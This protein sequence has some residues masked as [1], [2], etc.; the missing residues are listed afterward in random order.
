LSVSSGYQNF[1]TAQLTD[2]LKELNLRVDGFNADLSK[3]A[4]LKSR[5]PMIVALQ[6]EIT[7]KGN[8]LSSEETKLLKS[9]GDQ[10]RD[11]MTKAYS[12]LESKV[13][14]HNLTG[15]NIKVLSLY[16]LYKDFNQR[17]F[18]DPIHLTDAAN[19][20]LAKKLFTAIEPSFVLPS[21]AASE[22]TP[23]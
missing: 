23:R 11:R 16:Q 22:P 15:T 18:Y 19:E 10:Y 3:V 7:G 17:A 8:A 6:P 5:I 9:L 4:N 21:Q 12:I 14:N 13:L 20:I 2:N 1:N